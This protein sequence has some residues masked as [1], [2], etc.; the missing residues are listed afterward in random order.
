[1]FRHVLVRHAAFTRQT[2]L[3]RLRHA[4]FVSIFCL[5]LLAACASAPTP[6]TSGRHPDDPQAR[7]PAIAYRQAVSGYVSA[8]PVGPRPWRERN[9]NVAPK[10]KAQ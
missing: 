10:E 9:D 2:T 1:M 5:P 6:V 4:G 7:V 3:F 8:R